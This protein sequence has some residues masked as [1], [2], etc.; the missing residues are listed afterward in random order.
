MPNSTLFFME[1]L[2]RIIRMYREAINQEYRNRNP[3]PHDGDCLKIYLE[4]NYDTLFKNPE[5]ARIATESHCVV[6]SRHPDKC[7]YYL[8]AHGKC[9][10]TVAIIA[11]R[12][13]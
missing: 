2:L 11:M 9:K 10:E 3:C 4:A 5:L 7:P 12:S 6:H 13:S 8:M 1:D